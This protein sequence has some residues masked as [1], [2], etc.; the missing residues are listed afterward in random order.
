MTVADGSELPKKV[1]DRSDPSLNSY[2]GLAYAQTGNLERA[3]ELFE[4]AVRLSDEAPLYLATLA[5]AYGKSGMTGRAQEILE[6]LEHMEEPSPY[7]LALV[8]LGLDQND[9]DIG[10]IILQEDP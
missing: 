5:H 6:R 2:L 1:L 3:I 10:E 7:N 9:R 4:T 8:Q